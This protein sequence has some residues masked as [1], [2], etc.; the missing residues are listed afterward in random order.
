[1]QSVFLVRHALAPSNL[2]GS[3]SC[4]VPG[5]GLTSEGVEQ[6]CQLADALTSEE[7]ELGVASELRRTQETLELALAGR[8][9]PRI[10]VSELNEIDFGRFEGG[11]LDEYRSWAFSEPPTVRAPGGGESRAQVAARFARGVQRVLARPESV[12][13]LVG[14]ALVLRY[15]VDAA[16]GLAPAKRMAPVAHA[17]PQRLGEH[18]LQA[19]ADL[20]EAGS[21]APRFRDP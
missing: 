3:A 11:P 21:Q 16:R 19:A 17:V 6:A 12:V 1:V 10:V 4:A 2:E 9:V 8:D 7:I 20:L 14:H 15:I 18:E 13:L 5:E